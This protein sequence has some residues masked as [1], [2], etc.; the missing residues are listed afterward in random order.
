MYAPASVIH[1]GCP[2]STDQDREV[3]EI[4][5]LIPLKIRGI[6]LRLLFVRISATDWAVGRWDIEQSVALARHLRDFGLDLIDVSPEASF[7]GHASRW[8]RDTRFRC[9]GGSEM[10]RES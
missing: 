2:A 3:P 8:G 1:H 6:T 5:L 7:P 9:P 4:D 10:K